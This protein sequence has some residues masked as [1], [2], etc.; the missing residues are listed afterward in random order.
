MNPQ[1][2]IAVASTVIPNMLKQAVKQS[3]LSL[4]EMNPQDQQAKSVNNCG[5]SYACTEST[6]LE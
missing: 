5:W 2:M 3:V 4:L 1:A 6:I